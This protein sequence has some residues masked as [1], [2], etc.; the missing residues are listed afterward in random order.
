M[1]RSD[2]LSVRVLLI[3]VHH[4]CRSYELWE[5]QHV[6][7]YV[8][9][10]VKIKLDMFFNFNSYQECLHFEGSNF[11]LF[12]QGQICSLIST[13]GSIINFYHKLDRLCVVPPRLHNAVIKKIYCNANSTLFSTAILCNSHRFSHKMVKLKE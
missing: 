9:L 7:W 11:F 10:P 4:R 2:L 6:P 13:K 3:P 12:N 8:T 5:Y 1:V